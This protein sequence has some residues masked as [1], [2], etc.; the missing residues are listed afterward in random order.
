LGVGAH[1]ANKTDSTPLRTGKRS[2][3]LLLNSPMRNLPF[4]FGNPR[5][6]Q[7]IPNTKETASCRRNP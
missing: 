7:P 6:Q 1:N 2:T 4:S 5:T 3:R